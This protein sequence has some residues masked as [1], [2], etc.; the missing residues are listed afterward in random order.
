MLA[1]LI[2][3]ICVGIPVGG[4]MA[5]GAWRMYLDSRPA[6]PIQVLAARFASGEIDESEYTRKMQVLLTHPD[7]ALPPPS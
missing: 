6:D 2:V 4:G 3:L 5:L 1:F 7:D